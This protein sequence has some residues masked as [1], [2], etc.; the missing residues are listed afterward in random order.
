MVAAMTTVIRS[1]SQLKANLWFHLSEPQ[2]PLTEYDCK[3]YSLYPPQ[4]D[5]ALSEWPSR[6]GHLTQAL[7]LSCT[8]LQDNSRH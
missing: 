1:R 2:L 4:V 5:M 3:P 6:L 7:R 8:F